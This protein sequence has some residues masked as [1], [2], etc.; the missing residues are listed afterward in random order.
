LKLIF[1]H[2]GLKKKKKKKK[3]KKVMIMIMLIM[4]SIKVL[5]FR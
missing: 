5:G 2:E 3:K 4:G 1:S